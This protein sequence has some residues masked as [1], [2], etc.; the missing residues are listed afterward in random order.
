MKHIN[1]SPVPTHYGRAKLASVG[2]SPSGAPPAKVDPR[3]H[4][5]ELV[6]VSKARLDISDRD[7][8][9][10]RG[11][12]SLLPATAWGHQMMVFASNRVLAARCDG[13]DERTLR[14]CL[15]SLLTHG[16][17]ARNTAPNGKRYQVKDPG[18]A[19][20]L[21]YGI[22][23]SPLCDLL[24]HL[25]APALD[26]RREEMRVRTL[27][28]LIR[29]RLYHHASLAA[30]RIGGAAYRALRRKM[31]ADDLQDLLDQMQQYIEESQPLQIN[32]VTV[33]TTKTSASDSQNVRHIQSSNREDYG[34]E[35]VDE[36]RSV[37]SE[38]VPD[39]PKAA[40]DISVAECMEAATTA[41][42]MSASLPRTWQDVVRLAKSLG[43]SIGI[44][45]RSI[46]AADLKQG[47]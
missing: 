5:L 20:V 21:D 3:W 24:D 33:E 2:D 8:A 27:K 19:C 32:P 12:L 31:S 46:R 35:D 38:G 47:D 41:R 28:S 34:S 25:E 1:L 42:A 39:K 6:R 36:I 40:H 22:D 14:R 10:L 43:P 11:L 15:N 18:N 9:V 16:L 4:A 7:I 29:D 26:C 23:L 37:P 30:L 13:I 44:D 45:A 17:V